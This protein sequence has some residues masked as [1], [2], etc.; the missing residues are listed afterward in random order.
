MLELLCLVC[1]CSLL[2][3]PWCYSRAPG[4]AASTLTNHGTGL[5]L[6]FGAAR[7]LVASHFHNK[8]LGLVWNRGKTYEK[9]RIEFQGKW[10]L[11]ACLEWRNSDKSFR[12]TTTKVVLLEE[13]KNELRAKGKFPAVLAATLS[14]QANLLPC[15]LPLHR[16]PISTSGSMLQAR[17]A[18]LLLLGSG[19]LCGGGRTR[20]PRREVLELEQADGCNV[21]RSFIRHNLI[22]IK[23]I[24]HQANQST[25]HKSRQQEIVKLCVLSY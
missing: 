6:W 2:P 21:W 3:G 13:W 19:M 23:A 14:A 9:W 10:I 1:S 12:R 8:K 7:I 24:W 4:N 17:R 16:L 18:R 22:T 20:A 25:K 15:I 5:W 11:Y